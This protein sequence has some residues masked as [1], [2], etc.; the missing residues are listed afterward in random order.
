[1]VRQVVG[2][3][4]LITIRYQL[5]LR[6]MSTPVKGGW[7]MLGLSRNTVQLTLLSRAFFSEIEEKSQVNPFLSLGGITNVL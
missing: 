2:I 7:I 3:R 5:A 4:A 1:M 6:H